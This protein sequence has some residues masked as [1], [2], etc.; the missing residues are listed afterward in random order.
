MKSTSGD[1][2]STFVPGEQNSRLPSSAPCGA[3]THSAW[4]T[5]RSA[6]RWGAVVQ[7]VDAE[8]ALGQ[9]ELDLRGIGDPACAA[10]GDI[11]AAVP[12]C[13][14]IA[15]AHEPGAERQQRCGRDEFDK[16]AIEPNDVLDMAIGLGDF[17]DGKIAEADASQDVVVIADAGRITG[18]AAQRGGQKKSRVWRRMVQQDRERQKI[19]DEPVRVVRQIWRREHDVRAMQ[20]GRGVQ[21]CPIDEKPVAFATHAGRHGK[22]AQPAAAQEMQVAVF[23]G[24]AAWIEDDAFGVA[25][26]Q[27]VFVP[28]A[29]DVRLAAVI[30]GSVIDAAIGFLKHP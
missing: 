25:R 26:H 29:H 23:V 15:T 3:T 7:R 13:R 17:R 10:A 5:G 1:N 11:E 19:I 21:R 18:E 27:D 28:L 4:K 8:A 6:D 9:E 16:S 14:G 22:M 20:P 12:S 2:S 30:A 24:D